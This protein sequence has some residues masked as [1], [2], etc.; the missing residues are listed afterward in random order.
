MRQS[1]TLKKVR[2]DRLLH[3]LMRDIRPDLQEAQQIAQSGV[4]LIGDSVH[5]TPI[6]GGD[7]ADLAITDGLDLAEHIAA[8]GIEYLA[9]FYA[10]RH[11]SWDK[12]VTSSESELQR[13]HDNKL[14]QL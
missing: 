8:H 13:M 14:S 1:L 11:D 9:K 3:W 5:A 6:L 12:A 10:N 2:E 7:G 4:V